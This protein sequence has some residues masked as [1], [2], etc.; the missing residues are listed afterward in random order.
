MCPGVVS[1]IA[2]FRGAWYLLDL[3]FIPES[4]ATSQVMMM[5]MM[6]MNNDDDGD[7]DDND[8]IDVKWWG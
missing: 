4:E 3:Y 7:D 8:D 6:M 5:M 1:T 2:S